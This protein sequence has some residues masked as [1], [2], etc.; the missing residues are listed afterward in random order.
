MVNFNELAPEALTLASSTGVVAPER[1]PELLPYVPAMSAAASKPTHLRACWH[2]VVKSAVLVGG[3]TDGGV[4][5]G[6]GGVVV[7]G[8]VGG[9]VF[10]GG[11]EPTGEPPP[12]SPPAPQAHRTK[13]ISEASK[14]F[15]IGR[16]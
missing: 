8:V 9:V 15:L 4:V 11:A 16:L 13:A 14:R 2:L 10:E 6:G 7:G 5:V 1:M 3:V 12:A